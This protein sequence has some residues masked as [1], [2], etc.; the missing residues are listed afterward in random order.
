MSSQFQKAG[1]LVSGSIQRRA[2]AWTRVSGKSRT[3]DIHFHA[4]PFAVMPFV[5][6]VVSNRNQSMEFRRDLCVD[7]I[8]LLELFDRIDPS[9]SFVR[10]FPHFAAR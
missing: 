9:A 7:R 6:W 3:F 1:K 10:H 2:I 5:G 4:S 8:K